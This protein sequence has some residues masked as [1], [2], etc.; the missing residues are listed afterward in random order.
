[1]MT[2]STKQQLN[3]RSSTEAELIAVDNVITKVVLASKFLFEQGFNPGVPLLNQDNKSAI[4]LET[5]A[6][7]SV[8]GNHLLLCTHL[9]FIS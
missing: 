8:K 2:M 4:L 3:T 6:M 1:M 9:S 5:K 7:G